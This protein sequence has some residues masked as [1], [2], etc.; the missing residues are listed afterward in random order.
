MVGILD[1]GHNGPPQGMPS[2]H[3]SERD[4]RHATVLVPSRKTLTKLTV[5]GG[6]FMDADST[7]TRARWRIGAVGDR[8]RIA[9]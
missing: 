6:I 1:H 9:E 8:Q 2:R 4:Q 3:S 7:N 5:D